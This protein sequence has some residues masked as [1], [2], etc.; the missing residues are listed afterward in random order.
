VFLEKGTLSLLKYFK[1]VN[2]QDI[3]LD[4][5]SKLVIDRFGKGAFETGT[6]IVLDE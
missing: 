4:N 2:Q 1:T 5:A 6:G 3:Q